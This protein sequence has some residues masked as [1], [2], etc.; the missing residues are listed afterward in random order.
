MPVQDLR[1][2]IARVD[3]MGELTRRGRRRRAPRARRHRR[4]LPVGNGQPG[5]AV[6]SD[7]RLPARPSLLANVFTSLPAHRAQP[8]P[9]ARVRPARFRAGLAHPAQGPPADAGRARWSAGRCWRTSSAATQ[10]DITR[11]RRR[12]GTR[13]DGG[14]FLG[15]G[16]IVVMRDPDSGWVNCGTYR[17]QAHDGQTAGLYIS[18]GKHGRMIRQKYWERGEACP[19]AVS[20]GHDPLLLLLGGLE[21]DYGKNEYD[22]AGGDPRR[23]A[24]SWSARRTRACPCPPTPRSSSRAR[25]RPDEARQEGPFG[26]WTGYY[27]S[28]AQGRA[29]HPRRARCSTATTRSSSAACP[30]CRRTTTPSSAAPCAPR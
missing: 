9:A 25:S 10:V 19:V 14:R 12:S 17:V 28:G 2:W 3:E 5:A 26:E 20:M 15:T 13:D 29:D 22:V 30:G 23:A 7:R 1:E 16:N 27:A 4:P 11:S 6:R 21:V 24:R 8:E 18:P